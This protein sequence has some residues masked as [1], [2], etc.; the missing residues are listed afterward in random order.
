MVMVRQVEL[1]IRLMEW[2]RESDLALK[3]HLII[4]FLLLLSLSLRNKDDW[5]IMDCRIIVIFVW[6]FA[7][8]F[9]IVYYRI[10]F[11]LAIF[12]VCANRQKFGTN[13][14]KFSNLDYFRMRP[15]RYIPQS[16]SWNSGVDDVSQYIFFHRRWND[17]PSQKIP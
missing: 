8:I 6:L 15:Q 12:I 17:H 7:I 1:I 10:S 9:L 5:G 16:S 14:G 3:W 2:G 13:R 11:Y 4:L